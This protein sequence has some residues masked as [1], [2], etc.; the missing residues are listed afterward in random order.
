MEQRE[1][2]E[3]QRD[4]EARA[5]ARAREE[6]AAGDDDVG[7]RHTLSHRHARVAPPL[8]IAVLSYLGLPP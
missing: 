7:R 5:R 8:F 2:G 4:G 6:R 1:G 3:C